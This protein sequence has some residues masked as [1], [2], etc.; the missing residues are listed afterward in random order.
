MDMI[1][2]SEFPA[3]KP[4]EIKVFG[5]GGA[6]NNAV[7]TMISQ[8]VQ[9][10]SFICA[11]TDAQ[12][13]D[14]CAADI[15]LQIG[16]KRTRGLGAGSNPQV[17]AD[18][19]ME[20]IDAIRDA[21]GDADMI[22]ITAGMG[23]GTGTGAA[24]I[25]A[26]VA[27]ELD[28]LTVG[29]VT[30]PFKFECDKRHRAAEAGIEELRNYVDS[31]ILVPNERLFTLGSKKAKML[32]MLKI[33]DS[34]LCSAVRGISDLITSDGLMN[35]DFA[36]VRAAM[37]GSGGLA[38]M[39]VGVASGEGRA[40]AA[41]KNAINSP[42]LDD[43]SIV[44]A[45]AVLINITA[46]SELGMDEFGEANNFITEA[47][48][49]GMEL[50]QLIKPGA[51]IDESLGDEL[52]VTVIATGLESIAKQAANQPSATVTHFNSANRIMPVT[53]AGMVRPAEPRIVS[54]PRPSLVP[55]LSSD[56]RESPAIY[57]RNAQQPAVH[58]PGQEDSFTFGVEEDIDIPSCFR[59]QAN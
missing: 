54:R 3:T 21:I 17:G 52:R 11:N 57:R 51:V 43:V 48:S 44:G 14:K 15:R 28:V 10:V 2:G 45:K 23:G 59:K 39:G 47:A 7:Q 35:V 6:G 22:F 50:D 36:D 20:S 9:G 31:L 53:N 27:R 5:V 8:G 38:M 46:T 55:N 49:A 32:D 26:K 29:V 12:F 58:S 18:A 34:V 33:C 56:E 1:L 40:L 16:A 24:P 4:A 42:L 37:S 13:L 30:R 25:V 19:A 41:A